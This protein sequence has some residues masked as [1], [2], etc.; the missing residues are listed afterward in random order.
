MGWGR[1]WAQAFQVRQ[2]ICSSTTRLPHLPPLPL[3]PTCCRGPS[4]P[5]G[6]P[7]ARLSAPFLHLLKISLPLWFIFCSD[8]CSPHTHPP[9]KKK[10]KPT[11][12]GNRCELGCRGAQLGLLPQHDVLGCMPGVVGEPSPAA[13]SSL[14][15]TSGFFAATLATLAGGAALSNGSGDL[16]RPPNPSCSMG[17]L[18]CW[19]SLGA[20][21]I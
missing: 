9:R 14:K 13:E 10:K 21:R 17:A 15:L 20:A 3:S 7:I 16:G 5:P 2:D 11:E 19:K 4:R 18:R 8:V 6:S 1:G 12:K